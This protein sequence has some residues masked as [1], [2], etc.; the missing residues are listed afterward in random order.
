MKNGKG[1]V[2]WSLFLGLSL[3]DRDTFLPGQL[4]PKSRM[5]EN[6]STVPLAKV[7]TRY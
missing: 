7:H 2:K 4:L 5:K 1:K 6:S 3:T